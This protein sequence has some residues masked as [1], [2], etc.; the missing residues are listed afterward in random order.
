MRSCCRPPVGSP[1]GSGGS[2]SSFFPS[3]L[4][5]MASLLCGTRHQHA[6]ADPGVH[7]A[8]R[9]RRRHAAAG[10]GHSA[11]ELS[12][13]RARHRDGRLRHRHR[14]RTGHRAHPW[15]AGSP[16]AIRGAGISTSTCPLACSRSSWPECLIE[17]RPN[18]PAQAAG[19]H[20]LSGLWPDGCCG[21]VRCNW[22]STKDRSRT[23]SCAVWILLDR[24]PRCRSPPSSA[25]WCASPRL[26]RPD[27]STAGARAIATSSPGTLITAI[28]GFIL[29]GVTALLPLFLQTQ[30]GYTA[31]DSEAGG[32]PARHR[33][34]CC[35]CWWRAGCRTA[36]GRAHA[37]G[38]RAGHLRRLHALC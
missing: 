1:D 32:E 16:T 14:G 20:R 37:A 30:I 15:A 7:P 19:R 12:A 23:G 4:F 21:W 2:A 38:H 25:S 5:T 10:P 35:Q 31:L 17:A 36:S 27:R 8:G 33:D 13:A 26:P 28:Y 18:I 9:G 34:Q 6:H 3:I 11:R 22:C 29:Y 24:L